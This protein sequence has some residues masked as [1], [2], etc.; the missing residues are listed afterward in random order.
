VADRPEPQDIAGIVL[1]GGNSRRMGR[2]K[3]LLR[4]GGVTLIERVVARLRPQVGSLVISANGDPARFDRLGHPVVADAIPECGPLGGVLAGMNW[5]RATGARYVL[6]VACDTPFLP[7][8][9]ALRLAG[10]PGE[11]ARPAA[12]AC[13]GGREHH[14]FALQ[15][16]SGAPELERWLARSEQRSLRGWL[17]TR[18]PLPIAFEGHPDPFFNVNTPPDLALAE[19]WIA[20]FETR[21]P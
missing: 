9:L 20:A 21:S 13:S 11:A 4:L 12:V 14:A 3:S 1:A 6:T 18:Q 17:A 7:T 16:T 8:D 10:R 2:E 19:T 15:P 5:A